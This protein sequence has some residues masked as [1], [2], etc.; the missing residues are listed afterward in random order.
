MASEAQQDG[1]CTACSPPLVVRQKISESHRDKELGSSTQLKMVQLKW[2]P[3]AQNTFGI[4]FDAEATNAFP[5]MKP[6]LQSPS[7]ESI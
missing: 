5:I 4:A 3:T 2:V 7:E 1:R 6:F